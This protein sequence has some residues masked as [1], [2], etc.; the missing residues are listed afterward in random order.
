[1]KILPQAAECSFQVEPSQVNP[2]QQ[3]PSGRC[4]IVIFEIF[5]VNL[6]DTFQPGQ[7]YGDSQNHDGAFGRPPVILLEEFQQDKARQLAHCD[8]QH[9]AHGDLGQF[10]PDVDLADTVHTQKDNEQH[11]HENDFN[12]D[13]KLKSR[14]PT[15][16]LGYIQQFSVKTRSR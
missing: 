15:A 3:C 6:G 2:S 4:S 14:S 13:V 11:D 1:M 8:S 16:A 5:Q 10:G 9:D 12:P 7:K